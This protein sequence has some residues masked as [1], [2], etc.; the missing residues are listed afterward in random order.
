MKTS[1]RLAAPIYL[2]WNATA[3]L[4]P[5]AVEAMI[6][7]AQVG[8]ANPSSVHAFGRA[9]R[10]M[11]EQARVAVAELTG[12]DPRD[13]IFTS[14]GTEANNLALRSLFTQENQGILALSRLEHPSVLRVAEQL[15]RERK[16]RL[17]W[18]K[19]RPTG[20]IDL[21]DLAHA[22]KQQSIRMVT[23]QAINHET[24]VIQP[25]EEALQLIQNHPHTHLHCDAIQAFGK[26]HKPALGA[27]SRS[28]ASHKIRGP[29][30]IGALILKPG[31]SISPLLLGGSQERGMRPG[32]LDPVAA[33][34][35]AAAARYALGLPERYAR[36]SQLRDQLEREL[37]AIAV[38]ARVNGKTGPR[39]PHITSIT[40]PHWKG[41]EL[42]AALDLEGICISSG[43]ACSA[44]TIDPSPVIEAMYDR[45][46][47]LASTRISLGDTTTAREIQ[48]VLQ[49]FRRVLTRR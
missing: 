18:L 21:S 43:S 11:V 44:G 31:I 41:D 12:A 1:Y 2:D 26:Y 34:G 33:A 32:T 16:A 4:L 3:P 13:I 22:L 7:A 19:I 42:A 25:I 6:H 17:R 47:A 8:W 36:L 14:G 39:A 24:G 27:D 29:K 37:L 40:W 15:E 28:I 30:G 46:R 38:D 48:E 9:A 5:E 20:E 49:G 45:E 10:G 35:F 23:L